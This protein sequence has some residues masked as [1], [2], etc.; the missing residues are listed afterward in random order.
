MSKEEEEEEMK[1]EE[2]SQGRQRP[3]HMAGHVQDFGLDPE[4][5][6]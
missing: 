6:D 1:E 2:E 4:G 3:G 5:S